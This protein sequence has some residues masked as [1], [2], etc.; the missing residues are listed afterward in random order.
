MV[1]PMAVNDD[2]F[3]GVTGALLLTSLFDSST[4]GFGK[5]LSEVEVEVVAEEMD[6][7]GGVFVALLLL[8]RLCHLII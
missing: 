4:I 6:F 3:S 1:P 7:R 5:D 2:L 8:L